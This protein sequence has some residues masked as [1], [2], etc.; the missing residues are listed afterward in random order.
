MVTVRFDVRSDLRYV[1]GRISG[2]LG[3]GVLRLAL[4]TACFETL[5]RPEALDRVGYSAR[6]GEAITTITTALGRESGYR[7]TV[8]RFASLGHTVLNLRV[9]AHDLPDDCGFDGLLGLNFLRDFNC[10]V[11]SKEGRILVERAAG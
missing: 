6:D 10:E 5:I 2:P 8:S 3:D 7:L 1:T 4:D 11:R 9:H